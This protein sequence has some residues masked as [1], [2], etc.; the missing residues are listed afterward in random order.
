MK[1]LGVS[2]VT[3]GAV[4]SVDSSQIK[5]KNAK[6]IINSDGNAII[7]VLVHSTQQF[8]STQLCCD[9]SCLA[10]QNFV[11]LWSLFG[12]LD[13]LLLAAQFWTSVF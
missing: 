8:F 3:H 13:G 6:K 4:T 10:A 12:F 7:N 11:A 9:T 2:H 1:L 5:Q